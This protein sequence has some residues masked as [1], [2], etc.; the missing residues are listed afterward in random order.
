[1]KGQALHLVWLVWLVWLGCILVQ[2]DQ[3]KYSL[4]FRWEV[5]KFLHVLYLLFL[6]ATVV[7]LPWCI[8]LKSSTYKQGREETCKLRPS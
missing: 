8:S 6:L 2:T 1:M 7:S 5:S 3:C 4:Q